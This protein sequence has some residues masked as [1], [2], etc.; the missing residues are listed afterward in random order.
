MPEVIG[1]VTPR[2][3]ANR[4]TITFQLRKPQTA[5]L[6]HHLGCCM[7]AL[8]YPEDPLADVQ[9]FVAKAVVL[10]VQ[11]TLL[12]TLRKNNCLGNNKK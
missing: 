1:R 3:R 7:S 11:F 10:Y 9:M 8:K 12:A 6:Q 4:F 5:T 2:I